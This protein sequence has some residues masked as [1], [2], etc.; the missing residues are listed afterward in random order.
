[1]YPLRPLRRAR[2]RWTHTP[3]WPSWKAGLGIHPYPLP[4]STR[5]PGPGGQGPS[6]KGGSWSS[7]PLGSR[8][9]SAG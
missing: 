3:L 9:R 4:S 6:E 7:S 8:R 2:H 1:M 5:A